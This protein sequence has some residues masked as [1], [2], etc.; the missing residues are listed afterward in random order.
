MKKILKFL[1]VWAL[2][3]GIGGLFAWSALWKIEDPALFAEQVTAYGMLPDVLVGLFALVLPMM[4]LLAGLMLIATPW[5]KEAALVV[6]LMLVMFIAALS[7]A[8]MMDLDISCGCFGDET[9]ETGRAYLVKTILRDLALL[10]PSLFL[11]F[12]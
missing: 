3:I 4:E 8:A 1:L 2:R 10:F 9:G 11:L 5:R 12:A 6:S 7:Y